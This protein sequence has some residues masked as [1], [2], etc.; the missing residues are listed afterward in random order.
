MGRAEDRKKKKFMRKK[1][2]KAN[3]QS[4]KTVS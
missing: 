1:V 2:S 3:E 4:K